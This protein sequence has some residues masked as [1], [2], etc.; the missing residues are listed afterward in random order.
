MGPP[1]LIGLVVNT[2]FLCIYFRN[3]I[4]PISVQKKKESESD[5]FNS[6]SPVNEKDEGESSEEEEDN[7]QES[8]LKRKHDKQDVDEDEKQMKKQIRILSMANLTKIHK[9]TDAPRTPEQQKNEKTPLLQGSP[10]PLLRQ[11]SLRSPAFLPNMR[12]TMDNL[13]DAAPVMAS[14]FPAGEVTPTSATPITYGAI[15]RSPVAI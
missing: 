12:R 9:N 2:I 6:P 7:Q 15:G 14:S 11:A 13:N 3:D 1:A 5:D 4:S 8:R 10:R